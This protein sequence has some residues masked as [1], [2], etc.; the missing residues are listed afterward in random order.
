MKEIAL[1]LQGKL[2]EIALVLAEG[3][4]FDGIKIEEDGIEYLSSTTYHQSDTEY[5]RFF[6]SWDEITKP[7]EYFHDRKRLAKEK[8]EQDK[9]KY[10]KSLAASAKRDKRR[11]YEK[12]KKEFED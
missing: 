4:D 7:I 6:V 3:S 8:E 9:I 11:M 12:L 1:K 2:E 5:Y 10:E